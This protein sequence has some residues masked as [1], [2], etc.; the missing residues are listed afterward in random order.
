ME[1]VII[2]VLVASGFVFLIVEIFIVPGFSVPGIVGIT[3]VG[4]GIYR[5]HGTYGSTGAAVTL[6]GSAVLAVIV[7]R[8]ALRSR[9]MSRVGLDFTEHGHKSSDDYSALVGVTGTALTD[10]R[11]AGTAVINDRR[12]DVVTDGVYIAKDTQIRVVKVE[13]VRVIV[14]PHGGEGVSE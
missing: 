14:E 12:C 7:I 1:A 9:S 3:M 8:I 11:P 13:G 6:V 4:Y 2:A 10:L 5:A